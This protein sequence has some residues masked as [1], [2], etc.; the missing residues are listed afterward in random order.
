MLAMT[1]G[2]ASTN[3]KAVGKAVSVMKSVAAA[4]WAHSWLAVDRLWT[5]FEK[6]RGN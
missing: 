4:N 1:P 3:Y 2:L 6:D 5:G